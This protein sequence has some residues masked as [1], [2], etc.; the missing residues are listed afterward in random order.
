MLNL[1]AALLVFSLF[2]DITPASDQ[3]A[4]PPWPSQIEVSRD[5]SFN[6]LQRIYLNEVPDLLMSA[7]I[8]AVAEAAAGSMDQASWPT[9]AD[10]VTQLVYQAQ[11][12]ELEKLCGADMEDEPGGAAGLIEQAYAR[13]LAHTNLRGNNEL[14]EKLL[15]TAFGTNLTPRVAIVGLSIGCSASTLALASLLAHA[16]VPCGVVSRSRDGL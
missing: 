11:L 5:P 8:L 2:G 1:L 16:S 10:S 7:H 15:P 6:E 9:R 12:K 4:L 13:V 14:T 3:C